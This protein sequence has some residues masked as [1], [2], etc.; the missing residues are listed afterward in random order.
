MNFVDYS[1]LAPVPVRAFTIAQG[2][3]FSYNNGIAT[4]SVGNASTTFHVGDGKGTYVNADG[5]MIVNDAQIYAD[6]GMSLPA[7]GGM[8]VS[9]G[10]ANFVADYEGGYH[11]MPYRGQD[12]SNRTI[13]FGHVIT[14]ADGNKYDN[15]ISREA[16]LALFKSDVQGAVSSVNRFLSTNKVRLTQQQFDSLVSFTFNAGA[17]W[18][19]NSGLRSVLLD[20]AMNSAAI[21]Y[22]MMRWV[23]SEGV[24]SAGLYRRRSDEVQMFNDGNYVR[25][26]PTAPAGYK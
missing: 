7:Y 24:K 15:G 21:E 1:G 8:G 18:M 6:L 2:M 3:G 9:E 5:R 26:Y 19:N 10:L 11:G 17:S 22:E 4:V 20:G 13:G 23:Y 25:D 16:A 12:S 14:S